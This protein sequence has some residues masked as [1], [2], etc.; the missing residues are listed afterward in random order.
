METLHSLRL[1]DAIRR[2]IEQGRPTLAVCV[3]LQVLT[4]ASEESPGVEGL[5]VIPGVVRRFPETV[6]VPQLGWNRVT[7]GPGF[8]AAADDDYAYFAN[9]Y[10]LTGAP[11]G[12]LAAW[13]DHG[14]PFVAA[15]EQEGTPGVLGCQ[16]HPELSGAWGMAIL[17]RWLGCAEAD[18]SALRARGGSETRPTR[19]RG[20]SETRPTSTRPALA[21]RIIPCL[22][23]SNGRVVKGVRFA[24]LR[25]AG[26]PAELAALYERQGA[27]EI[28][29]LDVSATP[30]NR[31][32]QV[33][34]V[35]GVRERLSI[36]LTVGGGVRR[37]EDARALLA[38]GADKVAANTAAVGRPEL[39]RELAERFGRQCTILAIDAKSTSNGGWEVVTRSG[40]NRTGIDA[41]DWA[42]RGGE[43]GAGEILLTSF[44]RDGTLSG[45]D[46]EL[47]RRVSGAVNVPVIASGG[48]A[49]TD[50]MRDA[51]DAGADAVLAASI[52][53][54]A[55]TTV[56]D[57]KRELREMG[58]EV[59]L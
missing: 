38:A 26:D 24:N 10:R 51:I 9:S 15:I 39:I 7:Q 59:R 47:L 40:A 32:T 23:V 50:H 5:G 52:F 30:E 27:D 53:H 58:A 18:E 4:E 44:D 1:I 17:Q 43:L 46:L 37:V 45:Y 54:D 11:D 22:D 14:G 12:W 34:M 56:N 57:V 3:G 41:V 48:A 42:Q 13:S 28:V 8:G 55:R 2:R 25:D 31:G 16:F 35:R 6:R 33:E 29:F 36:P 20:G 49:T 19:K 21:R